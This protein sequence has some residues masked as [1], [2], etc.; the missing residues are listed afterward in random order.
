[1]PGNYKGIH[2]RESS[3]KTPA[4]HR[5]GVKKGAVILKR[6][7]QL[8]SPYHAVNREVRLC[9]ETVFYNKDKAFRGS[10]DNLL[11]CIVYAKANKQER[12]AISLQRGIT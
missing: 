9:D 12:P 10:K 4:G 3:R 5:F 6:N 2:A 8:G 7:L 1:M 11:K